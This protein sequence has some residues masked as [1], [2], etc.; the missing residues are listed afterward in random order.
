MEKW[1]PGDNEITEHQKWSP[2]CPIINNMETCN[3]PIIEIDSLLGEDVCGP[4]NMDMQT[5]MIH[6]QKSNDKRIFYL[7]EF[8]IIAL[9]FNV[10]ENNDDF[11]LENTKTGEF[12][13][14]NKLILQE[15]LFLTNELLRVNIKHPF[16]Q[17]VPS[18]YAKIYQ[19]DTDSYKIKVNNKQI[20]L[21][22]RDLFSLLD[23]E[24]F[25][26]IVYINCL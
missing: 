26:N 8:K 14:L 20:I 25:V 17:T 23:I 7:N 5:H 3:M 12:I 22:E 10:F 11:K 1:V 18:K 9:I 19:V 16:L 24:K 21:V 2:Q 6:N 4:Y 15:V 13:V